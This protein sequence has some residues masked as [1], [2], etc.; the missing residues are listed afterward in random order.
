MKRQWLL[1]VLLILVAPILAPGINYATPNQSVSENFTNTTTD[2][3]IVKN[4]TTSTNIQNTTT[5]VVNNTTTA[6]V[7]NTVNIQK[8]NQT[9][10]TSN[11]TQNSSYDTSTQ[12]KTIQNDSVA[13]PD[14]YQNVRAV[15]I[16]KDEAASV[17]LDELLKSGITDVFV[18]ANR[19]YSPNYTTVLTDTLN[20]FNGTGIRIH[21]WVSCF[22]DGQEKWVNPVN[23]TAFNEQLVS[24]IVNIAK[25][26]DIDGIHLDYVRYPGTAYKYEGGTEAITNFVKTVDEALHAINPN[27]ALSAALMP[28]GAVN[29]YYY[30]QDYAALSE[31]L[32]FLV[33]MVY[34]GN[35]NKDTNWIGATTK[36]IVEHSS[37]PVVVGLQS[38]GSDSNI[39]KL[40]A[41][42]LNNDIKTALSN[43]ASGYALFRYGLVDK[44]FFNQTNTSTNTNVTKNTTNTTVNNNSGSNS[45]VKF[46]LAEIVDAAGRVKSYV[47]TNRALPNY[48]Q[49]GSVK[50]SMPEFL[51]LLTA[52]VGQVKKWC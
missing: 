49:M 42:E 39:T 4:N 17:N 41:S 28:E 12:T 2:S 11:K 10:S 25:N 18:K 34:K 13:A 36:W 27:I 31:Y 38:Y 6:V 32:D 33:P 5:T 8:Q 14:R 26:Y 22:I 24:Y 35:Y 40:P 29:A 51:R 7:N 45:Q 43:G 19:F 1:V 9:T 23:N 30:G 44:T 15:W 37:K 52:W 3:E 20:K 21:A 50:V 46:T 48:V 16:S 47:E